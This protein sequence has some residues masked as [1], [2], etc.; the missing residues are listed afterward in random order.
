MG[1]EDRLQ[2]GLRLYNEGRFTEAL[3][4]FELGNWSDSANSMCYKT[5][6]LFTFG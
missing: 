6:A 3:Q 2:I 4:Q 5:G 1:G